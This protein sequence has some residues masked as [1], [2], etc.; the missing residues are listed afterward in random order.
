MTYK[1]EPVRLHQKREGPLGEEIK[2]RS[3]VEVKGKSSEKEG[4]NVN[5]TGTQ[6]GHCRGALKG[7]LV[8]QRTGFLQKVG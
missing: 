3:I 5:Y 4:P 6:G 1:D 7:Q 2:V 8:S